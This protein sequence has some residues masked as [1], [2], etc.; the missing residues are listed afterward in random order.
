[1][2]G[3]RIGAAELVEMEAGAPAVVLAPG[4]LLPHA[5]PLLAL[6]LKEGVLVRPGGETAR[7]LPLPPWAKLLALVGPEAAAER[8]L[9]LLPPGLPVL[10]DATALLGRLAE[11]LRE[12]RR[13]AEAAAAERD[14]LKRALAGQGA[15]LPR[16]VIALPP[17]AGTEPAAPPLTQPL[18][19]AAEG[20]CTVELHVAARAASGLIVRLLAGAQVIGL[21]RVPAAALL[22]G[23]LALD[24]P[25]PATATEDAILEVLAEP[26][27]APPQLSPSADHP[28]ASLALRAWTA[29]P[30][31]AVLP[32]HFDWAA[33]G[34]PRPALPLPLPAA[35]LSEAVTEGARV[36]LVA[37]GAEPARLLLELPPGG[38]AR[39]TLPATPI[40]PADLL[41]LRL[42]QIGAA[43]SPISAAIE[44]TGLA[45]ERVASGWRE[46]DSSGAL[47]VALPLPPGPMATLALALR[48]RGSAPALLELSGIAL[49][50]G[51][52]GEPRR[53]P[54]AEA[55]SASRAAVMLPGTSPGVQPAGWRAAPPAPRLSAA[56]PGGSPAP[57]S[58]AAPIQAPPGAAGFQE[59][60]VNQHLVNAEG[61]YSHLDIGV[62]GLVSGG[63]LWRQL[64]LK[65]FDRRGA[66]GLEFREAKGW[67]QMFDVWPVGGSD[68]YGPFWRLDTEAA[69]AALPAL[70]TPHDRALIAALLDVLPDL[71][72][73]AAAAAG[74]A[75]PEAEL[76]AAR[77][78]RVAQAV[79]EVRGV[80]AAG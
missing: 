16:R 48:H 44:V 53:P 25:E 30:G 4:I 47:A 2:I 9:P 63:G 69:A 40:G 65:L 74:L 60:K 20:L 13:S 42:V 46:L 37:A 5:P 62:A 45:G 24:L 8:L 43:A 64:R 78:R 58:L 23:W 56:G 77:A 7:S 36:E 61:T 79:A 15:A 14:G 76:W 28:R 57:P 38:E 22:P 68:N 33:S 75:G 39:L 32:R 51:A 29:P 27:A 31:W 55:S 66:A 73:K 26:G 1:M 12:A 70:A 21:W 10:P 72:A 49:Q 67:P 3:L 54:P 50:A 6:T 80:R 41:R 71:A 19:R 11:V 52:A 18:G 34:T 35:L 59:V 17:G